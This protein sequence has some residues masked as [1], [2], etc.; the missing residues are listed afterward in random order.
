MKDRFFEA[1]KAN[2]RAIIDQKSQAFMQRIEKLEG[3]VNECIEEFKKKA[4]KGKHIVVCVQRPKVEE[5]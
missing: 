4:D 3:Y 1:Y 2:Y 5:L